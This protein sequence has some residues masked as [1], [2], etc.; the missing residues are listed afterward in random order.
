MLGRLLLI[1]VQLVV[2]WYAS[3]EIMKSMPNIGSLDIFVLAG[4]FAVIVW[5]IGLLAGAVFK[6][7]SQPGAPGLLVAFASAVLFALLGGFP[8]VQNAV[9]TVTGNL[10]ARL[11]PLIGAVVGYAI[12]G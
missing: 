12:Q 9:I 3:L 1:L 5:A 8:E 10:D 6:D 2:G 7:L 4:V 11:Y